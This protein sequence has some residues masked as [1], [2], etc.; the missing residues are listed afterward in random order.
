MTRAAIIGLSG[1]I[2]AA[3]EAA[4]LE[5]FRPAGVILFARNVVSPSQLRDLAEAVRAILGP[6]APILVDQEGGRVARLRPPHWE[7][8]PAAMAF[9]GAPTPA[10]AANATLIG[11][12]CV[13][14]G[15]DVVCAP[16]LDLR[17]PGR[18]A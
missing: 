5:R 6:V 13:A 16:V 9:E 12:A 4:L 15:L 3:Q 8:F 14:A 7:A 10:V 11:T 1:P 18:M 17:L 2:L